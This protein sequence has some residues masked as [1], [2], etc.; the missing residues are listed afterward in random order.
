M[1]R[2]SFLMK[3]EKCFKIQVL[4][5]EKKAMILGKNIIP[6]LSSKR[7]SHTSQPGDSKAPRHVLIYGVINIKVQDISCKQVTKIT[8]H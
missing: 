3:M 1:V 2:H 7:Y 4:E 6:S 5:A 8:T